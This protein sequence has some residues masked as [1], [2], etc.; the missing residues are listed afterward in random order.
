MFREMTTVAPGSLAPPWQ[1]AQQGH[2]R[3]A[4]PWLQASLHPTS[5]PVVVPLGSGACRKEAIL[6]SYQ[7]G[8]PAYC[9]SCLCCQA[10]W[11]PCHHLTH[12]HSLLPS[13]VDSK[14]PPPPLPGAV[15]LLP[16]R[17]DPVIRNC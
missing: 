16:H 9:P 15:R 8:Q 2:P 13:W 3:G 1:L 11:G 4:T 10:G 17:R 14:E 5:A 7:R 12:T 6:S